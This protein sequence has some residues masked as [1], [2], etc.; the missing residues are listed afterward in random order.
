MQIE[1]FKA[2]TAWYKAISSLSDEE[3][4]RFIKAL[5]NYVQTGEERHYGGKEDLLIMVA[6]AYVE[7]NTK[8]EQHE[9]EYEEACKVKRTDREVSRWRNEV[10]ARD[11]YRCVRCGNTDKLNVHHIQPWKD[12]PELRTSIENGIT[13]C[14][15][16]HKD[17]HSLMSK[18]NR[19]NEE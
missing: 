15:K 5:L 10:L 13:L 17:V 4:G 7:R 1:W 18:L 12:N 3:A 16:C 2:D 19:E 11:N 8:N 14:E 9:A 6:C